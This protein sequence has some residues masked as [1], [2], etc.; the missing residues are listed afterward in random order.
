MHASIEVTVKVALLHTSIEVTVRSV[1]V[2]VELFIHTS[3]DVMAKIGLLSSR[4]VYGCNAKVST[5]A[6]IHYIYRS[7][8]IGST[9]HTH[10]Y[11][12]KGSG[13][14]MCYGS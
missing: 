14:Y 9:L 13:I 4:H 5:L 7:N 3:V 6:Y 10:I 8:D 2:K 11:R 1:T 12:C